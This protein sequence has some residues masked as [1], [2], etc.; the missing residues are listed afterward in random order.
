VLLDLSS[1][2]DTV[3]HDILL[4]VLE[5]RFGVDGV[6]I[7]MVSVLPPN[8]LQTFMVNG[9]SSRTQRVDCCVSQG[10]CLGPVEFMT[11]MENVASVFGRH[12][13]NHRLFADDKQVYAST[14]LEDVDDIRGRLH[15]CTTDISNWC[16]SRRL[17]HNENK[18]ERAWFGKRSRLNKLV[19]MEQTM[20]V[21]ASVIRSAAAVRDLGQEVSMTQHIV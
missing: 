13:T 18:T 20:T 11:N 21:G 3:D 7:T 8:R 5:R 15:D 17:Q 6:C 10:S 1:V 19:N 9:K 14:P 16:A 4:S 2:F 12:T